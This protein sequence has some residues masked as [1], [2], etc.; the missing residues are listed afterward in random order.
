M[1]MLHFSRRVLSLA[2]LPATLAVCG[3]ASSSDPAASSVGASGSGGGIAAGAAAH[4]AGLN[5]YHRAITTGSPEAQAWFDQGIQFL[6]GFNHDEAIRSF[7]AAAA[8]DPGCAMAHWGE[9]YALGL[10][11]NNPQM[12][13]EQSRLA[14]EASRRALAVVDNAS[15]VE[16]RLIRAVALRYEWPVPESRRPLDEAYADAM[17]SAY[18][19]F[20]NDPDVGAFFA[21]S[22]MN[23]QPW[24]LWTH[25]GAPKG[26]TTEIL[27]VL[28]HAIGVDEDHPGANHFYIHAI[29]ASPWPERGTPSAE[30]L[31]GLVPGSGHLVHMPSH[32]FIRTGR[33]ADAAD[34]NSRAIDADERYFSRAPD[35]DFYSLYYL[36]NLHFLAYASMMEGRYEA[37]MG[38]AR[39]I[40]TNIPADFLREN[41]KC[42]DGFMPTA[43]HVLIRFGKWEEVLL[44]PE[45]DA[46]RLLSRAERH[47]ARA[48]ALANLSR[49]AEARRELSAFDAV[50]AQMDDGWFMGNNPASSVVT[51]ARSMA[52]GEIAFKSGDPETAFGLLREAV[53]QEDLL[54][55]DEPPGWMQPVRHALGALLLADGRAA[56]AEG[57]YREDLRRHQNNGWALLGLHQALVAQ[58]R[59]AD[60]REIEGA[61]AVAWSRA[62]VRPVA[63][64]YCHPDAAE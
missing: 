54:V 28:E 15:P 55:Y 53:A 17:E 26:R 6:Y 24:D 62:D 64:C 29:E 16:Q 47:Y 58:G 25:D 18:E 10:H 42:A 11:I 44:E 9:A 1:P 59:D 2:V 60:A 39:R 45:P 12:G 8:A 50:V 4:Y 30:R 41:V 61:K 32:I 31:V 63:S 3:C 19:E 49:I 38:A 37:A 52:A 23:L 22:M 20:P 48:V 51:I 46:Y 33:Y 40:E 36:H 14:F 21:E 57:V 43:L 35:P 27:A 34:A 56:E 13:E 7:R 5:G